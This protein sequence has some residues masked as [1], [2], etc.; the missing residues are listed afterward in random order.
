MEIDRYIFESKEEWK[1][2]RKGMFTSSRISEI[3][4]NGK[5]L[6]TADELA[7]Y[8]KTNP[9]SQAKY[10]EDETVLSDGAISYI[11]DL[12]QNVEALPKVDFYSS[13]ME[14]GN[15]TEPEAVSKFC[16]LYGYSLDSDDV[17]YT[18]L[19]GTVF[20]VADGF[21]GSTPDLICK[22][23]TAQIKCPDSDTHLYY[24]LFVNEDNF[25]TK[26]PNY[27]DQIQTELML[28]EKP[29]CKFFSFDPRFKE[30]QMKHHTIEIKANVIRQNQIY[31]KAKLCDAKRNEFLKILKSKVDIV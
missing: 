15:T 31:N 4:P 21:L 11:L 22:T 29:S 27:S 25:A 1:D 6:M 26:L 30:E 24:K 16:E 17:I 13:A 19:G 18:S 12:I 7:E 10:K 28:C 8:K 23:E 2:F 5:I 20:F 14:W 3:M 9:K